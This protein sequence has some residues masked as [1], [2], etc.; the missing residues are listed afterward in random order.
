M[1]RKIADRQRT[2]MFNFSAFEAHIRIHHVPFVCFETIVWQHFAR[3]LNI[4]FDL[5]RPGT[6]TRVHANQRT[7]IGQTQ[8]TGLNIPFQFRARFSGGVGQRAVDVAV[9]DAAVEVP[10]VKNGRFFGIDFGNQM[11]VRFKR[12]GIRQQHAGQFIQ[13][14]QRIAGKFKLKIDAPHIHRVVDRAN[15]RHAGVTGT[16]VRLHRERRAFA[17]QRQHAAN[18]PFTAEGPIVVASFCRQA[19]DIVAHACRV[20][21]CFRA[22]DLAK[23][24]RFAQRIDEDLHIRLAD[25]IVDGDP[26]AIEKN[27]VE[28]E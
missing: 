20:A 19:E 11:P 17:P 6:F 24:Q 8:L 10:V 3:R 25:L 27:I 4:L 2:A 1:G 18:F 9:A 28:T 14:A 16:E 26:S 12:R 21:F 7:K 23:R 13:F 15:E 5:F 22:R